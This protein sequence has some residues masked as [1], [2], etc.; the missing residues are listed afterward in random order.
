MKKL[1][2]SVFV[3]CAAVSSAGAQSQW[4]SLPQPEGANVSALLQSG[5]VTYAAC[6]DGMYTSSD[7]GAHWNLVNEAFAKA[8]DLKNINVY[9]GVQLHQG[10]AKVY[11]SFTGNKKHEMAYT[12]DEGKTW[13]AVSFTGITTKSYYQPPITVFQGAIVVLADK[14]IWMSTND[15]NSWQLKDSLPAVVGAQPTKAAFFNDANTA[16][17]LYRSQ[18]LCS[19]SASGKLTTLSLSGLPQKHYW[20]AG[21]LCKVGSNLV[22][23]IDSFDT[24]TQ[25]RGGTSVFRLQGTSW[26][27][28][29][30]F[31]RSNNP[32]KLIS[33]G[34]SALVQ[35][36]RYPLV[37]TFRSNADASM[38]TDLKLDTTSLQAQ[39]FA[40]VLPLGN[41]LLYAT[42][43][44][45]YKSTIDFAQLVF[46]S[47]GLSSGSFT[48]ICTDGNAVYVL[49]KSAIFQSTDKG[50]SFKRIEVPANFSADDMGLKVYNKTIYL[51][52]PNSF[53]PSDTV[54]YISKDD[55][56]TW[57][58]SGIPA[59]ASRKTKRILAVNPSG[60]LL[61]VD[62]G[63][64]QKR[65]YSSIDQGKTWADITANFPIN[66]KTFQINVLG[67]KPGEF[68]M[69]LAYTKFGGSTNEEILEAH[70]TASN[71]STWT[72]IKGID[73][74][75]LPAGRI[76]S[77]FAKD[78]FYVLVKHIGKTSDSLFRIKPTGAEFLARQSYA[79]YTFHASEL[80][81]INNQFVVLGFDSSNVAA[82]P[83]LLRSANKG[84]T[85]APFNKGFAPHVSF[86]YRPVHLAFID[87]MIFAITASS[88]VWR[89]GDAVVTEI[90]THDFD[91]TSAWYPN[92]SSGLFYM[93]GLKPTAQV[94]VYNLLG[95]LVRTQSGTEPL[96]LTG[97]AKGLYL[98]QVWEDGHASFGKIIIE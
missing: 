53:F 52:R 77:A 97:Q 67:G 25:A 98:V 35:I 2:L 28:T 96:D 71:G 58:P 70:Y 82:T 48:A 68:L 76:L 43:T 50:V 92:P 38:W 24:K 39:L 3:F 36:Q 45:V 9:Y 62:E 22:A 34:N 12:A 51:Y 87:T 23:V 72:R 40:S 59:A 84:K 14:Y 1:F 88:G 6:S 81:C 17:Y 79:P 54:L 15:G 49:N 4:N 31:G 41:T 64:G 91:P 90:K 61:D 33:L 46:Q 85:Y 20:D 5:T 65:F 94:E 32:G 78:S 30:D 80:Y 29:Y 44:G 86:D 73:A 60:F 21:K 89:Y 16:L 83:T 74:H 69:T 10:S 13:T 42:E 47:K 93:Q 27:K 7:N 63:A 37:R 56:K 11:A 8:V 55:G 19:V 75:K 18:Q 95:E 66:G 57:Q 26:T